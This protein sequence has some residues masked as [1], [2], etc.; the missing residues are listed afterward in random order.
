MDESFWREKWRENRLGWHQPQA[1]PM[2]V[3][4]LAGLRIAPGSRI[5]LPLCGKTLDVG[6]LLGQGFRVAGSELVETAI[7]QL[8]DELGVAPSIERAGALLRYSADGIDIFVGDLFDLTADELGPVDAVYDRA[9]LVA[10]PPETRP[11]YAAHVAAITARARQLLITF[12]YDQ[13]LMD[14]PPFSVAE[15]EVMALYAAAFEIDLLESAEVEGGLKGF[16][17]ATERAWA[18]TPPRIA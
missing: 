5:F 13:S 3:R 14:G 9:A 4:R 12:E 15:E 2:L 8:F 18:L 6:W 16:C 7:R 17:P 10:L 11:A 1:H